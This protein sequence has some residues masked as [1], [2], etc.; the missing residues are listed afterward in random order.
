MRVVAVRGL[1]GWVVVAG[2]VGPQAGSRW[3]ARSEA[4]TND[5]VAGEDRRMMLVDP[6]ERFRPCRDLL[7]AA[8]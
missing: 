2:R 7:L 3:S 4:R 8:A 5:L 1:F 6:V